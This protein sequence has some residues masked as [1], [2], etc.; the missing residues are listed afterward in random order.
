VIEC[1]ITCGE[2]DMK[3]EAEVDWLSHHDSGRDNVTSVDRQFN[4]FSYQ[5]RESFRETG[6]SAG[7]YGRRRRASATT[8][9]ST[10]KEN[11]SLLKSVQSTETTSHERIKPS[12]RIT[13]TVYFKSNG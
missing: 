10:L 12:L 11:R 1:E 6:I 13:M 3:E 7:S 8:S 4:A 5:L 2:V 9:N